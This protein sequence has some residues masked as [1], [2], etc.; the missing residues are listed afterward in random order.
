MYSDEYNRS[1]ETLANLNR[2]K[3]R[4]L[5]PICG[6]YYDKWFWRTPCCGA[7]IVWEDKEEEEMDAVK[8][9]Q[10]IKDIKEALCIIRHYGTC[11]LRA[12]GVDEASER[13]TKI[14]D[15]WESEVQNAD[16]D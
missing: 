7:E 11:D 9:E 3:E 13:L 4:M 10:D 2:K 6:R 16:N 1:L 12:D 8:I 14:T 15:K 5:C